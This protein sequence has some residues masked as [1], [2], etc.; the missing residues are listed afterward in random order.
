ML[1]HACD[2]AAGE[3][4]AHAFELARGERPRLVVRATRAIARDIAEIALATP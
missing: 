2:G 3:N 4:C 1:N